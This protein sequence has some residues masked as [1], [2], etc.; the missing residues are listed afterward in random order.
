MST[1]WQG[2][3]NVF[4]Y[5]RRVLKLLNRKPSGLEPYDKILVGYYINGLASKR[6]RDLATVSY[7]KPDS[8]ET[9][10]QAVRGVMRL[11]EQ[12]KIKGYKSYIDANGDYDTSEDDE[13][14]S[15]DDNDDD[16]SD[17][18]GSSSFYDSDAESDASGYRK[19]AR[20]K[21]GF[22]KGKRSS[23]K[24]EKRA[25]SKERKSMKGQDSEGLVRGE[26]RELKKMMCVMDQK[27]TALPN[28]SRE[29][30]KPE[31]DIIPLDT[32]ALAVG[33]R[34]YPQPNRYLHE[35]PASSYTTDWCQEYPNRRGYVS[36]YADFNER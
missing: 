4:S 6:L 13:E 10:Y 7:L 33:Y 23:R 2:D 11:A 14:D 22:G 27:M 18:E 5:S 15:N 19:T 12:L 20:K 26:V 35:Q 16:D 31:E 34:R 1:L 28:T 17:H 36:Q 30:T 3:R 29:G 21:K 32:Y 9:P 24:R 25:K 8:R